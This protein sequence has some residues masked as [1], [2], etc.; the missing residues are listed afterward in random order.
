MESSCSSAAA[1]EGHH[2]LVLLLVGGHAVLQVQEGNGAQF[3]GHTARPPSDVF[4]PRVE[5]SLNDGMIG[6]RQV[7]GEG[8]ETAPRTLVSLEKELNFPAK[9]EIAKKSNIKIQQL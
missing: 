4:A 5:Q 9:I 2:A 8:V 1:F 3:G 6:G 7:G